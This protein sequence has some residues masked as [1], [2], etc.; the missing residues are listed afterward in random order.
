MEIS[1]WTLRPNMLHQRSL[2]GLLWPQLSV[3]PLKTKFCQMFLLL[4]N[5]CILIKTK[6]FHNISRKYK[7]KTKCSFFFFTTARSVNAWNLTVPSDVHADF[8]VLCYWRVIKTKQNLKYIW[9]ILQKQVFVDF[10][11]GNNM[12][13]AV[14]LGKSWLSKPMEKPSEKTHWNCEARHPVDSRTKPFI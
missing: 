4:S 10:P 9:W 13:K 11:L 3:H 7:L 5:K 1:Q 8:K 2:S 12:C 6:T 14:N